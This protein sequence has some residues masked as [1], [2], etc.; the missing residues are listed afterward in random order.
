M[1]RPTIP[2]AD[3]AN[4]PGVEMTAYTNISLQSARRMTHC[5]LQLFAVGNA[6]AGT[7]SSNGSGGPRTVSLPP[8]QPNSYCSALMAF[9]VSKHDSLGVSLG[10]EMKL[11]DP[12]LKI[13][14]HSLLVI[15]DTTGKAFGRID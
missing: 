4:M 2:L 8:L 6:D 7:G 10:T 12:P 13:R 14:P 1:T 5:H 15:M 11:S 3:I 9:A